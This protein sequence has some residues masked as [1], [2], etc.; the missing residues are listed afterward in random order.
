MVLPHP[1][2]APQYPAYQQSP[3]EREAIFEMPGGEVPTRRE[4]FSARRAIPKSDEPPD[5]SWKK[6]YRQNL[7]RWQRRNRVEKHLDSFLDSTFFRRFRITLTLAAAVTFFSL[8]WYMKTHKWRAPWQKE[9]SSA[10]VPASVTSRSAPGAAN[11]PLNEKNLIDATAALQGL[12]TPGPGVE[13][14][15]GPKPAPEASTANQTT[16]TDPKVPQ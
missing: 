14:G 13:F 6:A 12:A 10:S 16:G 4:P 5:D 9:P 3:P 2:M 11:E 1:T 7:R 15:E 8:A